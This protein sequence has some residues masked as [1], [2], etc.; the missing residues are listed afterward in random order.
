MLAVRALPPAASPPGL[1]ESSNRFSAGHLFSPFQSSTSIRNVLLAVSRWRLR[2]D[3]CTR[4]RQEDRSARVISAELLLTGF[5]MPPPLPHARLLRVGK[6]KNGAVLD[7][8][9]G[10]SLSAA[11]G[12]SIQDLKLYVAS[13]RWLLAYDHRRDANALLTL[14]QPLYRSAISRYYYAM[15]HSMR[16]SAF[17]FHNGDDY[18][19]HSKLPLNIPND[20][21]GAAGWETSLKNARSSRNAA[22]YDPYPRGE[23]HWR[24]LTQAIR[25]D[26]DALLIETR[27]Y[28][29]AKGCGRI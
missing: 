20:F 28:L 12:L 24:S 15:Y 27:D 2:T 13:D 11:S 19:E 3:I 6:A 8:Q 22:D 25:A 4:P 16:A 9:E 21:P 29:R 26:A 1:E 7:W 18:E 17:V 5:T 14:A 23:A 10:V